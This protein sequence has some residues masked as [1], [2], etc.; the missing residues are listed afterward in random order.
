MLPSQGPLAGIGDLPSWD[1]L[2]SFLVLSEEL[3]IG[4]AAARLGVSS[5]TLSRRMKELEAA[6]GTGLLVVTTRRVVLTGPGET[7]RGH[8]VQIDQE[9][10]RAAV[11]VQR[12]VPGRSL[13]VGVSNDLQS[14][15]HR[16]VHDWVDERRLPTQLDRL[17]PDQGVRLLRSGALDLFLMV[18]EIHVDVRELVVAHEPLVVVFPYEH[19]AAASSV[20]R[21]GELRDLPVVVSDAGDITQHRQTVDALHGS[22]DLPY[23]VAPRRG[24][25]APGLVWTARSE[26]AAA[27][28]LEHYA[29]HCDTNGLAVRPMD[30]PVTLPVVLLGRRDIPDEPFTSLGD[31]LLTNEPART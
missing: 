4:H 24:T 18:G 25:I 27:L 9:V 17:A 20:I 13:S 29:R 21:I 6:V 23:V 30:P 12:D 7:L 11:A 10:R 5:R 28:V 15:W 1:L 31:C 3:H 19:P 26:H 22:P 14:G 16:T 8:A 2:W